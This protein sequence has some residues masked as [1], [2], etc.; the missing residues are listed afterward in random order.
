MSDSIRRTLLLR[1]GTGI[2][3]LFI[4]LSVSVYFTV[5]HGLYAE[6]DNSL[7]ETASI[8]ANQME[9]EHGEIIFE[10]EEGLGT[11]RDIADR[12]IF[13]YWNKLEK[14]T[15]RSP[16]L[17]DSDLPEF[18]GPGGKPDIETISVSGGMEHARAIGMTIFPYVLQEENREMVE[19]GIVFNPKLYPHTLVVARDLTLVL[20]I[21]AQLAT[22]LTIGTVVMFGIGFLLISRAIRSSLLPID[23]LTRDVR[24][25]T[26]DT[27]DVAIIVPGNLPSELSPLA[28]SFDELL[29]R[30]SAIRDREKDFIRHAAHELRTPIAALGSVTELALSRKRSAEE[31]AGH[32]EECAKTSAQLSELVNRLTGLARI[33]SSGE[34]ANISPVS[35]AKIL[36]DALGVF[37][38]RFKN[39]ELRVSSDLSKTDFTTLADP[40]LTTLIINNLLDNAASYA[41][42]G[43]TVSISLSRSAG[44][45]QISITNPIS[46]P[47]A[48]PERLFEPL[49][50]RDSSRTETADSHLGIGLT[51]S[52]DAA[53]AMG[54]SLTVICPEK[55]TI[56][57]TLSLSALR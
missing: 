51:L 34:K 41:P 1:C 44:G 19:S 54:G 43:S 13:Q 30:V 49:F 12:A 35:L 8:L 4:L 22:I 45:D 2:G 17:G 10:W 37:E 38:R 48:D 40:V 57:F 46:S 27:L 32:L 7:R 21:L 52:R 14:T 20:N 47:I 6:L 42:S 28:E 55:Q 29:G 26:G 24:N 25:R 39:R 36:N 31:Y 11:N 50:R 23:A 56:R 16:A 33:G 3:L 5:R 15:T 18:S 53:H 9:Y